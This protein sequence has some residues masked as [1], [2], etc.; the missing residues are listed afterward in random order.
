M[1][2]IE[3]DMILRASE[4]AKTLVNQI[5]PV[6]DQ[7]DLIYNSAGGAKET[8]TQAD[9]DAEKSLSGL[10]QQQLE[11]ALYVLAGTLREGLQN[12]Y[13]QLMHLAVRAPTWRN[14][15]SV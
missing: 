10:T 6:L 5:K 12:G 1:E 7:L 11:D 9:L 4:A 3:T 15:G 13:V 14:P 2:K 8:I